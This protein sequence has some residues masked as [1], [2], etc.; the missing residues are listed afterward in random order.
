MRRK[1]LAVCIVSV[2]LTGLAVA[3]QAV[4]AAAKGTH[5]T[6]GEIKN[7]ERA[8]RTPEQCSALA[9]YFAD[10]QR[11]YLGQA[12]QEKQEWD[13]RSQNVMVVAAKYPRPVD[14]ARNLHEYYM[15]KASEAAALSGK[16]S[17]LGAGAAPQK[18]Q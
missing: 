15:Y 4:P 10:Q 14:S 3:Q 1:I 6:P 11:R 9:T 17:Q 7:L 5:Y 12:E 2:A 13:R 18:A 8:V 16:Y